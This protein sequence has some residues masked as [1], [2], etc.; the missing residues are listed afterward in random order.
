MK[1]CWDN[2]K[3]F[4]LT[5]CGNL[6]KGTSV[7][8][9]K[10][11]CKKC[12]EPYL[13]CKAK[14]SDFCSTSC[15]RSETRKGN[16]NPM[17]G[18]KRLEFSEKMKG[19]GNPF[20]GKSHSEKTLKRQSDAK[21]GKN[22]PMFGK[23]GKNNPNYGKRRSENHKKKQSEL[24]MGRNNPNWRGGIACEPYC[25]IWFNKEF[26]KSILERDNYQCQN[27]GCYGTGSRLAG[28]HIDY[29]KKNCDPSNIITLCDSCNSRANFNRKYW[30]N[31]YQIIMNQK[32]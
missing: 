15:Q 7:Y 11:A 16:G 1:I 10:E 17:F 29:N 25:Q 22:N 23:E 24:V 14:P 27:P 21:K 19:M 5:K 6:K 32:I 3:D 26:K 9:I 4:Y 18:R 20:Y 31:F 28:H 30:M 13:T 12:G 2:L 8:I